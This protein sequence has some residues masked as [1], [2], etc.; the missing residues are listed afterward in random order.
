MRT[1]LSLVLLLLIGKIDSLGQYFSLQDS[2]FKVG[3]VYVSHK[4]IFN[5]NSDVFLP[6]SSVYL[7]SIAVF[8]LKNE[9][10]VIEIGVHRDERGKLEYSRLFTQKR[11]AA[12]A[13]YLVSKGIRSELL[14]AKGYEANE[15]IIVGAITEE[16]HW[17]NRR[18]EFKILGMTKE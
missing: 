15:P 3:D 8:L 10:L 16:Q 14:V 7:D 13:A 5:Y 6:E 4:M 11:A 1:T 17:M 12:I 9:T 2:E 18:T